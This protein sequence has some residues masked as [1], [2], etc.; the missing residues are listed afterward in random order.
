VRHAF[1]SLGQHLVDAC[2]VPQ[3]HASIR[4]MVKC[5]MRRGEMFRHPRA[6]IDVVRYFVRREWLALRD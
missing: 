3:N 1:K 2:A 5:G 4:V 6:P